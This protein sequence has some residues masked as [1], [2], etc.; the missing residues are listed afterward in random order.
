MTIG[1]LTFR[2][3]EQLAALLPL[4]LD[5]IDRETPAGFTAEV[6]VVDNDPAG[7]ARAVVVERSTDARVRYV[8]E[9]TPGIVA[10]RNRV[11]AECGGAR[12]LL[13]LDDDNLPGEQWLGPLLQTWQQHSP[14]AVCGRMVVQFDG[15]DP[16]FAAGGFFV[17]RSMPTGTE[18]AVAGTGAL[19]VDLDRVRALRLE[20]DPRF[21]LTGGE[22]TMFTST[23]TASGE[24]MVWCQEATVID[25]IP[26]DRLTRQWVLDRA[27]SHGNSSGVVRIVTAAPGRRPVV[28]V[29]VGVSGATR[30]VLGRL[31]QGWGVLRRAVVDRARGARLAHRGLGMLQAARGHVIEEYRRSEG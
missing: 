13:F 23:L 9:P 31:R 6:L 5:R 3:A 4:V 16:F 11:L 1:I 19:L 10:A 30:W 28:R 29:V 14:A 18:I 22:D 7:S 12:L 2:R 24:R 20:F 21:G 8:L 25:P 26:A 15:T 27:R 17:R